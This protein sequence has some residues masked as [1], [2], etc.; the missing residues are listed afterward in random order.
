MSNTIHT[1]SDG[2]ILS[3]VIKE[4]APV[5]SHH[6][7]NCLPGLQVTVVTVK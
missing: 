1:I 7:S 4:Y 5:I 3:E 6:L 2:T